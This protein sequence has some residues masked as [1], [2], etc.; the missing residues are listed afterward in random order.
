MALSQTTLW[1]IGTRHLCRCR[2][3]NLLLAE[4]R[5]S[6]PPSLLAS[7]NQSIYHNLQ[8]VTQR[9]VWTN[10]AVLA[11]SSASGRF[12]N[13]VYDAPDDVIPQVLTT[14]VQESSICTSFN[15]PRKSTILS[16]NKPHKVTIRIIQLKA[17]YTY[18]IIPKLS[19]HTYLKANILNTS[20]NY[21]F[22]PGDINVFMDGNFVA[23]SHIKAVS[24]NESFALFLG[25]DDAIKVTYPPGVFAKDTSGY[26]RK[27][28]L[29]TTKHVIT[30][31]NTK[32]KDISVT[33]FDQL[34]KSND[35]QIKVKLLKPN[36]EGATDVSLTDANNLMWKKEIP[37][38]KQ[39]QLPFEYQLEWPNGQELTL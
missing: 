38:G 7:N 34:P 35:S 30:V 2:R 18:V 6:S 26:L 37:S 3:L 9:A 33:I 19:T 13:A 17:Q 11:P 22:L 12:R 14:A 24:P 23:K 20:E 10:E 16:D 28:N 27:S 4:L 32:S 25:I 8:S 31:K 39:I 21:P 29:R 36:L 15:I 1:T 5:Q